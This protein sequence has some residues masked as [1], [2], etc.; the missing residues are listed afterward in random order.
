MQSYLNILTCLILSTLI[1]MIFYHH[2]LFYRRGNML[3]EGEEL[4]KI[5]ELESSGAG[6]PIPGLQ[7]AVLQTRSLISTLRDHTT[8]QVGG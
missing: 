8:V 1:R 4:P 7:P 3:R 5:P 6:I 2:R